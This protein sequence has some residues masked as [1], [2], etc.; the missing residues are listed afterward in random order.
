VK[1]FD[2]CFIAG[3]LSQAW[4]LGNIARARC[5]KMLPGA[6]RKQQIIFLFGL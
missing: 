3:C 6:C 4:K 1:I 2:A 5:T